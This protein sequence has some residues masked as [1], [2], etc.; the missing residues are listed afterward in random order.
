VKRLSFGTPCTCALVIGSIFS[1]G[2]MT[3]PALSQDNTEPNIRTV[4]RFTVTNT[5]DS[6]A[7][8]FRQAV[9]DA[10][11][12]PGADEI[13]FNLP[14]DG[15][16]TITITS[17]QIEIAD[18]LTISGLGRDRLTLTKSSS[19]RRL[20][21]INLGATVTLRGVTIA[22]SENTNGSTIGNFGYLKIYDSTFKNNAGTEGGAIVNGSSR[23]SATNISLFMDSVNFTNNTA[24]NQGGAILNFATI[25]FGQSTFEG[26]TA[27]SGGAVHNRKSG[28]LQLVSSTFVQNK[29]QT[30]GGIANEGDLLVVNSGFTSNIGLFQG[31][32][33]LNRG[34]ARIVSGV[35]RG[36]VAA[37]DTISWGK[38]TGVPI[39]PDAANG[40]AV[41][42]FKELVLESSTLENNQASGN[43]GGIFN[44]QGTARVQSSKIRTNTAGNT[45]PDV[46]GAF[47]NEGSNEIGNATGST[48]FEIQRSGDRVGLN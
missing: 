28:T 1:L 3:A 23:D 17:G 5:N 42:N 45:S 44:W 2:L 24:I 7:G 19:N 30:G 35:F 14:G 31:G 47:I 12:S 32:G 9:R 8:S 10:N 20:M 39:R 33:I 40:G 6:G 18:Q 46:S 15:M 43:G 16:K 34:T 36:N 4:K 38:E 13:V 11:A 41:L 27:N 37:G 26:N 25:I 22:N 29:A 21:R 48:G